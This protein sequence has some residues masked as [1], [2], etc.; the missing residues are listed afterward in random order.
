[1]C[2]IFGVWNITKQPVDV[3]RLLGSLQK[4]RHRGPDD[5][6]Y[7]L[8]DSSSREAASCLG[9][10]SAEHVKLPRIERVFDSKFNVALGFRRLSILDLSPAGHQP[11]SNE[12]GSLWIVFNGE[13]YNYIELREELKALGYTFRTQ[14]DTEVILNAYD[15]WG[16]DCLNRFNGMW[17]FALFDTRKNRLFCARD[18]FGIKPFYYHFDRKR[19]IFASEIKAILDYSDMERKPNDAI[20]YDYLNYA[21]MD[22]SEETFFESVNQLLPAHSLILE[23]GNV[24]IQRYWDLNPENK[25]SLASDADYEKRFLELFEDAIRVHLRSDVAIGSCLSGGLDSS[26]IVCVTNKLLFSDRVVEPELIGEQQKTFS[27]CFDDPRFDERQHIESV[28]TTTS[29]E[30]N[31]TFPTAQN[32]MEDIQRLTWHQDEPFGS[33]SIYAQWCV[34]RIAAQRGVRVL[35]DGQGSDEL[36]AGYHPY[37][38]SYW[39][40]LLSQGSFPALLR[41]W[42]AYRN[43]YGVSYS[44]LFQHT[45]FSIAPKAFQ[46]RVRAGRGALGLNSAFSSRFQSRYPDENMNFKSTPLSNRLYQA[47]VRSSLPALLRYEDRNS[48]AYSIEARVPFLDYRLVEFIFSLPEEQKIKNAQTKFVLRNSMKGV[49]P[50]PIRARMDKMGFVT[51]ER[52]WMSGELKNWVDDIFTSNSFAENPYLDVSKVKTLMADHRAGQRDLGSTL[53][54]WINLELWRNQQIVQGD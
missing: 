33:T 26:S 54:R 3:Q 22:H 37:F 21:L 48:M 53:W 6:G 49:L 47:L 8:V 9:P 17:G 39:G 46:R 23:N 5:E 32:L 24:Y 50:E 4:I 15:A 2:G 11:M 43:H 51:P 20:V 42:S 30:R 16:V 14:S 41:E 25:L 34:M 29:A 45:L 1:M 13:V 10:D 27:S 31:Y 28:L 40:T 18:R 36:L 35:M 38:D 44:Y 7:L 52:V 19:F 12:D